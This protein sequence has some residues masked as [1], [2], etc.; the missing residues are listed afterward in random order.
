MKSDLPWQT[1]VEN[2][3][4]ACFDDQRNAHAARL[5]NHQAAFLKENGSDLILE[6]YDSSRNEALNSLQ[7]FLPA[8]DWRVIEETPNRV[9][10]EIPVDKDAKRFARIVPFQTTRIL[11]LNPRGAWQIYDILNPC[12]SCQTTVPQKK[13]EPGRCPICRGSGEFIDRPCE[14]CEGTGECSRCRAEP[15]PGWQR[16]LFLER[17]S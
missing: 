12:L 8:T 15:S 14:Q 2:Y 1:V 11:L 4:Q 10:V 13:R 6:L 9:M 7:S 5:S 17:R 3:L 16:A